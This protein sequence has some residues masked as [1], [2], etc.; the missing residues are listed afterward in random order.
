MNHLKEIMDKKGL[1]YQQ[2]SIAVQQLRGEVISEGT[3]TKIIKYNYVPT[4]ETQR[5]LAETLSVSISDIW[6]GEA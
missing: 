2:L 5:A 6:E 3:L 4:D 1:N